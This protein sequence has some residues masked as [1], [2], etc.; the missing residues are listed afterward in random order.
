MI[1]ALQSPLLQLLFLLTPLLI[2]ERSLL[3]RS[4]NCRSKTT[5]WILLY[6]LHGWVLELVLR[7]LSSCGLL[8]TIIKAIFRVLRVNRRLLIRLLFLLLLRWELR[9][10]GIKNPNLPL[11]AVLLL[12][13]W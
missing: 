1:L 7:P 3:L 6:P 11:L 9:L 5:R 2:R 8:L 12:R 10:I 13:P 4:I